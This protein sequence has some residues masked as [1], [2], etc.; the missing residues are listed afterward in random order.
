MTVALIVTTGGRQT[1]KVIVEKDNFMIGRTSRC[2]LM[3]DDKNVSRE[4]AVLIAKAGGYEIRDRGSRNSTRLNG[5]QLT[6]QTRLK[7]GD[8]IQIGPFELRYLES[9]DSAAPAEADQDVEK[10]RFMESG[11]PPQKQK[12]AA[13][14]KKTDGGLVYKLTAVDGPMKG[15]SGAT[16]L[17]IS[18]SVAAPTTT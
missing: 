16:G 13:P 15:N 5:A 17:A 8:K 4:H 14:K 12:P 7:E 9:A 18:H 6:A 3:L 11:A 10:T 1:G 2:D